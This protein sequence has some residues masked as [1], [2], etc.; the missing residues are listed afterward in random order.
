MNK[1][2]DINRVHCGIIRVLETLDS[3]YNELFSDDTKAL[4]DRFNNIAVSAQYDKDSAKVIL[5]MFYLLEEYFMFKWEY[6]REQGLEGFV[7]KYIC[8]DK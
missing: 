7:E 3:N 1:Q 4:F 5:T 2:K 8:F 6:I